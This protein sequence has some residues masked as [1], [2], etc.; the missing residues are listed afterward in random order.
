MLSA[1]LVSVNDDLVMF[2]FGDN[3]ICFE[4]ES[5]SYSN[6]SQNIILIS[7][8]VNMLH[9]AHRHVLSSWVCQ[10]GMMG[11]EGFLYPSTSFWS[12]EVPVWLWGSKALSHSS[13]WNPS[14]CPVG[15]PSIKQVEA[16]QSQAGTWKRAGTQVL[17]N[18][19]LYWAPPQGHGQLL[20]KEPGHE[21]DPSWKQ[22]VVSW[23][24]RCAQGTW[25]AS[26]DQVQTCLLVGLKEAEDRNWELNVLTETWALYLADWQ[27]Q[28]NGAKWIQILQVVK[29]R[30]SESLL[31]IWI[32]RIPLLVLCVHPECIIC[33]PT[34]I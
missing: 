18:S 17:C 5:R 11:G 14:P 21:W 8:S 19:P 23:S 1:V 28:N 22:P 3:Y 15:S 7:D 30:F 13:S 9:C 33:V 31:W 27:D 2:T 20:S 24:G 34:K 25:T 29:Q 10:T 6:T 26:R 12:L 16:L 32:A 4:T